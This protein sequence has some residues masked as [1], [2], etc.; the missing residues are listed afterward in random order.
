MPRR[1]EQAAGTTPRLT[2]R[3]V[4]AAA[5]PTGRSGR[6]TSMLATGTVITSG[7]GACAEA[8]E[9]MLQAAMPPGPSRLDR[10]NA[11]AS[12]PMNP[13][14]ELIAVPASRPGARRAGT[15]GSLAPGLAAHKPQVNNG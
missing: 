13:P 11:A 10:R 7:S 8:G 14:H 1:A 4:P 9:P 3:T 5:A 2:Q 15:R 6:L 12:R